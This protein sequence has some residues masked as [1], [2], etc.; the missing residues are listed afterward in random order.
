MKRTLIVFGATCVVAFL[1]LHVLGFRDYVSIL[2]GTP[3][4]GGESGVFAAATGLLYAIAWFS[5]VLV[6]P[7]VFLSVAIHSGLERVPDRSFG[8]KSR[9]EQATG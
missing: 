2:S 5:A 1:V 6:A 4:P 7:I 8:R 3:G 9:A